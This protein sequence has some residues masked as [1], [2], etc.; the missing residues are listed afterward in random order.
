MARR[1][2]SR[3][4]P[5]LSLRRCRF[6]PG[7]LTWP[8]MPVGASLVA[9]AGGGGGGGPL[10]DGGGSG[11]GYD[12]GGHG[13]EALLSHDAPGGGDG[14]WFVPLFGWRLGGSTTPCSPGPT[15]D[16]LNQQPLSAPFSLSVVVGVLALRWQRI[17]W[18]DLSLRFLVVAAAPTSPSPWS[19]TPTTVGGATGTSSPQP[20]FRL[21]RWRSTCSTAT[22]TDRS[23]NAPSSSSAPSPSCTCS[24]GCGS[25]LSP[26][27]GTDRH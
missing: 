20:Q 27:P 5:L 4:H 2:R 22:L 25:T 9:G 17:R 23:G 19:G 1:H 12:G 8:F 14:S 26:G 11:G 15:Y 16:I 7:L 24:P 10:L 3:F 13:L 18:S 6:W 21:R